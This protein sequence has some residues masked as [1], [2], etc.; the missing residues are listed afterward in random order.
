MWCVRR[1]KQLAVATLGVAV[2][3]GVTV[4]GYMNLPP[5]DLGAVQINVSPG[6]GFLAYMAMTRGSGGI[7][8]YVLGQC[9]ATGL[10]LAG[11]VLLVST[12][13]DGRTP[14]LGKDD[15]G[16]LYKLL[17]DL[18]MQTPP[19]TKIEAGHISTMAWA[20]HAVVAGLRAIYSLFSAPGSAGMTR[21]RIRKFLAGELDGEAE[22]LV[23]PTGKVFDREM[24]TPHKAT[25]LSVAAEIADADEAGSISYRAFAFAACIFWA[26]QDGNPQAQQVVM[27]KLLDR[28]KSGYLTP[29][30]LEPWVRLLL[31]YKLVPENDLTV[32][33]WHLMAFRDVAAHELGSIYSSQCDVTG[34]GKIN[35]EE[36]ARMSV[37]FKFTPVFEEMVMAHTAASIGGT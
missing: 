2:G 8:F 33:S 14:G 9:V 37:K 25:M 18:R 24:L 1:K 30:A 10:T 13:I 21:E 17:S 16:D 28:D 27:F 20:D 34:R 6:M 3:H 5:V 7:I 23:M 12:W 22:G 31:K 26:A 15:T 4:A 29:T 11:A 32:R 19:P 35:M 36:F